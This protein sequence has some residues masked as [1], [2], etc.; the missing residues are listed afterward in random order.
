MSQENVFKTR[1]ADKT[2]TAA[3]GHRMEVSPQYSPRN[4]EWYF[5]WSFASHSDSCPCSTW[6]EGNYDVGEYAGEAE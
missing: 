1:P 4:D 5:V 2:Y 6:G 3:N